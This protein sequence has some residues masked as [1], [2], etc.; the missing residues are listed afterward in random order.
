M[1]IHIFFSSGDNSFTNDETQLQDSPMLLVASDN[2]CE[3]QPSTSRNVAP[4]IIV[5]YFPQGL[6][7]SSEERMQ[8]NFNLFLYDSLRLPTGLFPDDA[9]GEWYLNTCRQAEIIVHTMYRVERNGAEDRTRTQTTRKKE[10][11]NCPWRICF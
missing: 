3:N 9:T 8:F 10:E 4:V 11:M 7:V 5:T 1:A 6:V 2:Q